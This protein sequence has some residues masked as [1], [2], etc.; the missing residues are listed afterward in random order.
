MDYKHQRE[1]VARGTPEQLH[2]ASQLIEKLK[3]EAEKEMEITMKLDPK[4]IGLI[5][6]KGWQNWSPTLPGMK[7]AL[8]SNLA[9]NYEE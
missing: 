8:T 9:V 5:I 3:L 6:G 2:V 4:C 1:V 7:L